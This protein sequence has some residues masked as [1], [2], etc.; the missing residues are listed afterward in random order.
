[1]LPKRWPRR[2]SRSGDTVE[3]HDFANDAVARDLHRREMALGVEA[4]AR[5]WPSA[6]RSSP[7]AAQKVASIDHRVHR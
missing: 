7:R 2:R 1:L 6:Q 4:I 3:A 5:A